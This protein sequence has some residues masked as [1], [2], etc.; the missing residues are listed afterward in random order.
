MPNTAVEMLKA[1]R[2]QKAQELAALDQA[3]A[4]LEGN[5]MLVADRGAV[6]PSQRADFEGLGITDA[7]KRLVKELGRPL[8]TR[9]ISDGLLDRGMKTKSKNFTA[10]VYATLTNSKQFKRTKDERWEPLE[11]ESRG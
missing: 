8:T 7:A 1:E 6:L 4:L 5:A 11:E 10:T 2:N 3:I 9:E